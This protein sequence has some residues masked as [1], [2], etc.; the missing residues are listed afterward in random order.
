MSYRSCA[1]VT[2]ATGAIGEAITRGLATDCK[3]EVVLIVRNQDKAEHVVQRIQRATGNSN[4]R[5]ELADLSRGDAIRDLTARWDGPLHILVNNAAI[6][7]HRRKETPEGV[8]LQFAT[9][10]LAYY[11]M[12]RAFIPHLCAA[13]GA[14]VVNVASYWAGGLDLEDLE[15]HHRRYNNDAAYRQSKQADRLLSTA[16]AERLADQGVCVNACHPGDV[17]S[18][19][20]NNLGFGGHQSPEEGADTPVWLAIGNIGTKATGCYFEN[21]RNVPCEFSK[22][23]KSVERLFEVC[24]SYG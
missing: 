20:S 16:F 21:R 8:E 4:V 11:R 6:T 17:N 13:K 10:V 5:F 12:I 23:R 3:R 24:E 14:Q 9:N 19:L 18:T 15:F 2:G 22:D 1:I 7:S